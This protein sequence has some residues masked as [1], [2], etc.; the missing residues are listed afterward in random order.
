[1]PEP[2]AVVK[3][4]TKKRASRLGGALNWVVNGGDQ[5]LGGVAVRK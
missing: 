1:M 2:R 3:Q 5:A 4:A